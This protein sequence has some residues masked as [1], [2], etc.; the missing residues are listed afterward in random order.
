MAYGRF[1][2]LL[3]SSV[4]GTTT[5]ILCSVR[6][7]ILLSLQMQ[8]IPNAYWDQTTSDQRVQ[9]GDLKVFVADGSTQSS[10]IGQNTAEPSLISISPNYTWRWE[11]P[12]AR[13][14]NA[15]A[16]LIAKLGV[17]T[18]LSPQP[19]G[20]ITSSSLRFFVQADPA[21][22]ALHQLQVEF[23]IIAFDLSGI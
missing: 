15:A 12:Y 18:G 11:N 9:L 13:D 23:E 4:A 19:A 2:R 16:A 6:G 1:Q 17:A 20:L 3:S 5:D 21:L 7:G 22:A 14:I 10:P 8:S